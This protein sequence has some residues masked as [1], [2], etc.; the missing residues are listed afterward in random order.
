MPWFT[1]SRA[2]ETSGTC[3]INLAVSQH[4][5]QLFQH[6]TRLLDLKFSISTSLVFGKTKVI[7]WRML[8]N[9]H[10]ITA[11]DLLAPSETTA[12]RLDSDS[13]PS[14]QA[15]PS[16]PYPTLGVMKGRQTILLSCNSPR[17]EFWIT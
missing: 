11:P 6:L 7:A 10:I 9:S 1:P 3:L 8:L 16:F 15:F 2:H 4:I 17:D 12:A 14:P 5:A 13:E